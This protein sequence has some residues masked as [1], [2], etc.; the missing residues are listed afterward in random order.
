MAAAEGGAVGKAA[1]PTAPQK[2]ADVP[3]I[4]AAI[5]DGAAAAIADGAAAAI[6]DGA[7]AAI[8]DG[9]N[10]RGANAAAANAAEGS[11]ARETTL[12]TPQKKEKP[13]VASIII[14]V[15]ERDLERAQQAKEL[16]KKGPKRG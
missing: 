7:A 13:T 5:A 2:A 4:A 6:A 1:P 3:P 15:K 11:A 10:S 8:A 9:P 12:A 16:K 14:A